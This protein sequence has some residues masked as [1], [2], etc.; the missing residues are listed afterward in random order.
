[1]INDSSTKKKQLIKKILFAAIFAFLICAAFGLSSY[2]KYKKTYFDPYTQFREMELQALPQ[3]DQLNEETY[4][5]LPEPPSNF[6]FSRK[7]TYGIDSA[8]HMGRWM[9]VSFISLENYDNEFFE[10]Y[11][12]NLLNNNWILQKEE[13]GDQVRNSFYSKETSCIR[14][15]ITKAIPGTYFLEI[16]QNFESQP[17]ISNIP[18]QDVIGHYLLDSWII[19]KCP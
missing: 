18:S 19:A 4:Q 13:D 1:M 10:Y 6:K 5:E 8:W 17:F 16:W 14:L 3:F 15:S 7:T 2:L 9:T 11:G 12:T